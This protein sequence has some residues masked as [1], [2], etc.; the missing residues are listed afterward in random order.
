MLT[1]VFSVVAAQAQMTYQCTP[2]QPNYLNC[3]PCSVQETSVDF[4]FVIDVSPSM[5]SYI[6]A[7][8]AG[9]DTMV[10]E[11]STNKIDARF[12]IVEVSECTFVSVRVSAPLLNARES[13]LLGT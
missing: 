2:G 5:Q 9:L 8:H 13:S 7:V 3:N 12:A 6:D 1:L 4:L 11:I 10:N